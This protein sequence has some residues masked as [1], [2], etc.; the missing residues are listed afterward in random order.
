MHIHYLQKV[1]LRPNFEYVLS[2][3]EKFMLVECFY[4]NSTIDDLFKGWA[5]KFGWGK[6][7][8]KQCICTYFEVWTAMV[9]RDTSYKVW[10]FLIFLLHKKF[11][12]VLWICLYYDLFERLLQPF[13]IKLKSPSLAPQGPHNLHKLKKNYRIYHVHKSAL[14]NS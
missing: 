2:E 8:W 5:H 9:V 11:D 13:I 1:F 6:N 3:R 12:T 7:F 4:L 14:T 10:L